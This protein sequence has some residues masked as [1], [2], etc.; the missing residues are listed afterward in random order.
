MLDVNSTREIYGRVSFLRNN[1]K[2]MHKVEKWNLFNDLLL[3]HLTAF[4]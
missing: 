1:L 3:Q 2:K 4:D